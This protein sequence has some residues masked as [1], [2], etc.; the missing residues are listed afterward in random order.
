[1]EPITI[2]FIVG[3]IIVLGLAGYAGSLFYRLHQQKLM[4]Q[5]LKEQAIAKR[6]KTLLDNIHS[7]AAVGREKQCDPSE[8]VIRIRGLYD[9]LQPLPDF[10]QDY[11]AMAE[12]YEV[13]KDMPR[14]DA[15][16][17]YSKQERMKF[18][19]LRLKAE[20]RLLEAIELE[21]QKIATLTV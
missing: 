2:V 9:H 7:L 11:P 12:L 18:N 1:M 6:N 10:T 3:T 17:E 15:R 13:V 16:K 5:Q 4:Q 19:L 14:A 8:L 21:Y 20:A